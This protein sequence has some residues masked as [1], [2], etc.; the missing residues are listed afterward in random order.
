MSYKDFIRQLDDH[1]T[2]ADAER[3]YQDYLAS[4]WGSEQRREFEAK[5]DEQWMRAKYDP[6]EISQ[7]KDQHA[8]RVAELSNAFLTEVLE[9]KLDP[10][11]ED[12]HQGAGPDAP[13][14]PV[15]S[16]AD[17]EMA[18]AEKEGDD[19]K[20]D[21]A[22]EDEAAKEVA[23]E[24]DPT[25]KEP[26]EEE[27]TPE[28]I[29]A[30]AVKSQWAPAAA[31]Q[32]DR[33]AEDIKLSQQLIKKLDEE[34]GI[35]QNPL[36]PKPESPP[37]EEKDEAEEK[38]GME[39]ENP[40][41]EEPSHSVTLPSDPVA[42][43]DL[44]LTYLWRVHGLDYYAGEEH[45]PELLAEGAQMPEHRKLRLPQPAADKEVVGPSVEE[46]GES[47]SGVWQPRLESRGPFEPL[48]RTAQVE[49]QLGEWI[50]N[51][52]TQIEEN[53][54]GCKLSTKLFVAK[55]FVLKHIQGKHS[56]LVDAERERIL[57]E[58]YMKNFLEAEEQQAAAAASSAA[59]PMEEGGPGGGSGVGGGR[60][61]FFRHGPPGPMRRM[62]RGRHGPMGPMMGRGG[63]MMGGRGPMGAGGGRMMRGG[64]GYG[65]GMMMPPMGGGVLVP[66]PGA[67]PLGPFIMAQNP[68]VPMAGPMGIMGRGG[69][70]YVDLDAPKNNRAVL[71]YGDL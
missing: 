59:M 58:V 10:E 25:D 47:I 12:F 15:A 44:L 65:A 33:V 35:T 68:M 41:E 4:Y 56:H 7:L 9:G 13:K 2:P 54:W 20:K 62:G 28:E 23:G 1:I 24:E 37:P 52:V 53:K 30:T 6:R 16:A 49:E 48:L 38:D 50:E 71:D 3:C 17:A 64:G 29:K 36:V 45:T 5:K 21:A 34:N 19:A 66:A 22:P 39:E 69:R 67:G 57:D 42:H 43:L 51:Q 27:K 18:D 55:A 26:K 11:A 63:P 60:S 32:E 70:E 14:P 31:W 61:E 40:A 46:F 8:A